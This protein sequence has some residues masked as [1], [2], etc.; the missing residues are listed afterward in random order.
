MQT[1]A[2]LVA[3]AV[4]S[5]AVLATSACGDSGDKEAKDNETTSE[6]PTDAPAATGAECTAED[7]KVEGGFGDEPTIT[8]PDDCSPPTTLISKDLVAGGGAGAE[9]G[10]TVLANYHLVTWSDKQVLDSSFQRG[11]PYPV[12]NIG[13]AQVI[14]GWNQGLIGMKKGTR[15]L[16]IVPPALGYGAGGNGVQPDETLVFV[17]DAVDVS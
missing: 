10:G 17:I 8:I 6:A 14:E 13:Q 9:N 16:L 12:E 15:R 5:F 2:R 3:A 4:L 11:A 1:P 7:V